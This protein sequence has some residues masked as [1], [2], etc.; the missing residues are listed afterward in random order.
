V[1]KQEV[2][3]V[4]IGPYLYLHTTN[5]LVN[6]FIAFLAC[7]FCV[8]HI[9]HKIVGDGRGLDADTSAP[10]AVIMLTHQHRGLSPQQHLEV[11]TNTGA[12]NQYA[13][14][15]HKIYCVMTKENCKLDHQTVL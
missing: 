14:N 2:K 8:S 9:S 11:C 13:G 10:W 7:W 6:Y 3:T 1:I 4:Q 15:G 12:H 5:F